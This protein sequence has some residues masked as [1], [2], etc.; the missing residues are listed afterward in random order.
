IIDI[1]MDEA[2][3]DAVVEMQT[4]LKLL[5]SEPDI[6]RVPLMVDSSRWEVIE[7]GLQCVQGK[8]V[9]NSISLKEGEE[10]FLLRAR[11]IQSYGA[12]MIVMAFDEKG[13]ADTYERKVEICQRA[14]K[15]LTEKA[16]IP[17][18]DIIFDPNIFAIGTGIDEHSNYALDFFAA[19]RD[20]RRTMPLAGISGGVSNVSFSFRGNDAVREAIHAVFLYHAVQA[21]MNMGIVNPGQLA[22]YDDIQ[23][24]LLSRVEDLVCNRREDATE[25]LLDLADSVQ[26]K[27]VQKT[28]DLAWREQPVEKR[29]A[30]ALVKGLTAYISEDVE[31]ARQAAT[32]AL[33][34]IEGPLMDGMNQ[35]GKLFGEGKMFLPQVVKSARVMKAAV[36]HLLP[37]IEAEKK[38]SGDQQARGKVLMATVKGDVH[39][40][41]KNIVGVV[42]GCNNFEII[43]IG[44]MV[45]CQDII[46]AAKKH[47][48]D[49]IGLSGLITPSLEEMVNVASELERQGL[50]IPL[51]LG[52]ATTSAVH[53]AVKI[54]PCYHAPVAHV[55]DASLAVQIVNRMINDRKQLQIELDQDHER[56]RQ[57][58]ANQEQGADF[59]DLAEARAQRFDPG[60]DGYEPPRPALI[61][62]KHVIDYPLE[63]LRECID[64]T[65]FFHSW[66]FPGKYPEV[67]DHPQRGEEARQLIAD[68]NELLDLIIAGKKLQANGSLFLLPANSTSSDTIEIYSDDDRQHV[69]ARWH[70]LRQQ[71]RKKSNPHY[72]AL[73]D[74]IAPR[75][76]GI[77]DYIGG[78]AVTAGIGADEFAAEFAKAGDDYRAILVRI[79]A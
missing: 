21:G 75:E 70:T 56:R 79:L 37:Y 48:V 28:A 8:G 66:Q 68:A 44:V 73:S 4:F 72:Y 39:D 76:S 26:S 36:A 22:V 15:L 12:A 46:E 23:P 41:G 38:E 54:A 34:V 5:A 10:Q 60:W 18:H 55:K 14:Y 7:A 49:V 58:R 57:A 45:E 3:L 71:K 53:T 6:A 62:T 25:R 40:I 31:E 67:L 77:A 1:N 42:L 52:G 65:F 47:Q 51:M 59:L 2:M 63:T 9:V 20:I 13:Q 74:F 16:G 35:V 64:W 33:D 32:Q 78:F 19:A 61:G 17:G 43:D 29:L 30:Y 24:E 50:D 27:G 69:L 11:T